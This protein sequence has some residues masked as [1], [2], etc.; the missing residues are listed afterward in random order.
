[1]IINRAANLTQYAHALFWVT[2]DYESCS[3]KIRL[4]A[5]QA[6]PPYQQQ[7]IKSPPERILLFLQPLTIVTNLRP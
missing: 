3:L 2:L 5:S 6:S 1:M 4:Q 7:V